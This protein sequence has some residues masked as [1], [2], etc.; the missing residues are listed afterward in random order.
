MK[1]G[2]VQENK[3][4]HGKIFQLPGFDFSK[5]IELLNSKVSII[6]NSCWGGKTYHTL[7]MKFLSPFINMYIHDEDYLKL[8]VNL[9]YYLNCDLKFTR[10]KYAVDYKT[11]FPVCA[12]DDIEVFFKHYARIDEAKEKWYERCSRINW[13]NLFI[14]FYTEERDKLAAFERLN[15]AKKVCFV[16]FESD[17][18]SAATITFSETNIMKGLP[19]RKIINK[20]ATS[21]YYSYDAIQLLLEGKPNYRRVM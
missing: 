3:I 13:D 16:P 1:W 2:G 5:Y 19:W 9:K 14:M 20:L 10:W 15:Y 17:L 4:L 8:L 21:V 7:G 18:S 11:D 12:L 6:A